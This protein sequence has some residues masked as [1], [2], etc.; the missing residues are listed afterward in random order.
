MAFRARDLALT[1]AIWLEAIDEYLRQGGKSRGS[2]VVLD[3]NGDLPCEELKKEW[4]FSLAD[5]SDFV[6]KKIL[7]IELDHD[8]GVKRHWVDIRPIPKEDSW[9]ENIWSD[10]EA[11]KIIRKEE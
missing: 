4:S 10:F 11:G 2:A 7:E 1:H 5:P 8:M 9:F 3:P 6:N